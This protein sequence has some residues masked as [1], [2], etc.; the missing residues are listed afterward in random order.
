MT[1]HFVICDFMVGILLDNKTAPEA[2][3]KILALKS[4]LKEHGFRFGE[5]IQIILT[6]KRG[7]FR[8]DSEFENND[9]GT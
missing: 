7:E 8:N 2:A 5:I 1:I 4:L 3:G 9:D 6:D